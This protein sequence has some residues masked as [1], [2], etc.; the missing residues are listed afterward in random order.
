MTISPASGWRMPAMMRA[1]V[2]LPEP[3]SPASATISPGKT[4]RSTPSR[5][6]ILP[7]ALETF[8]RPSNARPIAYPA[9]LCAGTQAG[10]AASAVRAGSTRSSSRCGPATSWTPLGRASAG[11][12][13]QA[14]HRL[15]RS[16][17]TSASSAALS[18]HRGSVSAAPV[19]GGV[20]STPGAAAASPRSRAYPGQRHTRRAAGTGT[21]SPHR[22]PGRTSAVSGLRAGLLLV[23][24]RQFRWRRGRRRGRGG[25]HRLLERHEEPADRRRERAQPVHLLRY[26][27]A[28]VLEVLAQRLV[29]LDEPAVGQPQDVTGL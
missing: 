2:D 15:S 13:R 12:P 3:F 19:G 21:T 29:D 25:W 18:A 4:S 17:A 27:R 6:R 16:R 26:R 14:G 22:P 23:P 7:N 9:W 20:R 1:V 24:L 8:R 28:G 10:R 11:R 5:T